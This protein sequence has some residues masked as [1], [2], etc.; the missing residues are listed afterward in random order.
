MAE[1]AV[2]DLLSTAYDADPGSP[3]QVDVYAPQAWPGGAA[4]SA[5]AR[6]LGIPLRDFAPP[7][8]PFAKKD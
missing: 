2:D 8:S 3:G 6:D 7:G 5:Y 1:R 4:N